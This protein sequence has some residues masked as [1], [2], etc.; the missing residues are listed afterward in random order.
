M[1]EVR[2]GQ[3][4]GMH[5]WLQLYNEE[6]KGHLDYMG[7]I[8]PKRRGNNPLKEPIETERILTSQFKW[9]GKLKPISTSFIGA[10]PPHLLVSPCKQP[11]PNKSDC[12]LRFPGTSPEFELA[13]YT[14]CFMCGGEENLVDMG[15]YTVI[16]RCHRIARDV[17]H[18]LLSSSSI[19]SL[20]AHSTSLP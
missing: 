5:S 4:I 19:P 12:R 17:R 9:K 8:K 11:P 20:Q 13:L 7:Y 3:V 18:T 16:V 2:E 6:N 14:L 15:P 10:S 1:G